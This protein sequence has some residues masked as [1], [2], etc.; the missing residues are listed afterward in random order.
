MLTEASKRFVKNIAAALLVYRTHRYNVLFRQRA[1]FEN[2]LRVSVSTGE[3]GRVAQFLGI[4]L[5][6]LE[7]SFNFISTFEIDKYK[8]MWKS[9][10]KS[11]LPDTR[12]ITNIMND[13]IPIYNKYSD[14]MMR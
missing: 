1:E 5:E 6:Y 11:N 13:M 7:A 4:S 9:Y 12:I 3:F 2:I 8:Q 14:Y 10:D